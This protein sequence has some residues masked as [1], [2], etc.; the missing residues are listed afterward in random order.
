[1]D[2]RQFGNTLTALALAMLVLSTFWFRSGI[3]DS[4]V[5]KAFFPAEGTAYTRLRAEAA[6]ERTRGG[7]YGGSRAD[8]EANVTDV[9]RAERITDGKTGMAIFS[10]LLVVGLS[11]RASAINARR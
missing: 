1:M 7:G 9:A 2:F 10:A 8:G 11:V 5:A 3:P 4:W 6:F